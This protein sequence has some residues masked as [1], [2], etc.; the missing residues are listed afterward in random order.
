[1]VVVNNICIKQYSHSVIQWLQIIIYERFDHRFHLEQNS[2]GNLYLSLANSRKSIVFDTLISG[3]FSATSDL[4]Y[5]EWDASCESFAP[6]LG[7]PLP[8]P[9]L[10]ELPAP[11]IEQ[12]TDGYNIHYD[13]LGLTYWMLSRQEEVGCTD[14]DD[15]G[16]FPAS[17]SHAFKFGYLERPVVDE[18]LDILGQVIVRQWPQIILKQHQPRTLVSCDIDNPYLCYSKSFGKT[19]RVVLG[20]LF[21]RKSPA[22]AL[23]T[24]YRYNQIRRGNYNSDPYMS[25][26]DWMMDVNEA[27]GNKVSFYFITEQLHPAYDG[28]YSMDEPVIRNLLQRIH[29][30]GHEIGLHTSYT[31][32]QNMGQTKREAEILR[33][34][35]AEEGI[36]QRKFG[37]RQHYLRWVTPITA[38]NWDAA[39][40]AYDSTLGYAGRAGFRCGTCH[41]YPMI[42]PVNKQILNVRQR[43]L[44]LMECSVIDMAYMGL[45]YSEQSIKYMH[46]IKQHCYKVGGDF[47]LLWHNSHLRNKEDHSFYETLI[48]HKKYDELV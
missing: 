3:F 18:W 9:G 37:G 19:A 23:M 31:T 13:I 30:R 17:S 6:V 32:N 12:T 2:Q 41:E 22:A 24:L 42:D 33:K 14:L 1:M 40:M 4:P 5:C 7:K 47:T 38:H 36:S 43:P 16:R 27:A 39:G 48:Q 25:A 26:L 29:T 11:L 44:V 21:K 10:N 35:M 34:V 45:G 46:M 15:H 28:C 20:D 8:A